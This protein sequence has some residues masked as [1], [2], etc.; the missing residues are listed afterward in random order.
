MTKVYN[1]M[2]LAADGGQVTILCLLN[3]TAAFDTV[4]HDL[5]LFCLERQF[6]IHGVAVQ[7]FRSHLQGRS[8]HVIYSSST[9]TM[10][11]IVC[12]VPQ[13]SVLVLVLVS[14]VHFV[15]GGPIAEV[16]QKHNMNIHVF[17]DDTQL[18]KHCH[19]HEMTTTIAQLQ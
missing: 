13:G 4:D 8:F 2:L 16:V 19:R 17:A 7:W 5:L 12:S 1:D 6:G 3:L 14:D 15:Q 10:I 11:H 9:S 18:Y